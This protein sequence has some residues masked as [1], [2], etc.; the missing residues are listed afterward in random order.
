M[1]KEVSPES[2]DFSEYFD[3]DI[4]NENSGGYEYNLFIISYDNR[5]ISGLNAKTYEELQ[6][7]TNELYNAFQYVKDGCTDYEG[8]KYTYKQAMQENGLVYNP[9]KCSKLKKLFNDCRYPDDIETLAEYLTIKTGKHWDTTSASGYCQGDY[10]EILYCTEIYK[11]PE[12]YGELW[13]GCG[14]EFCFAYLDENGNVKDCSEVY[15]YFVA[16][17]QY[18]TDEELKKVLCEYEGT[19]PEETKVLLIDYNTMHTYTK[20]Q[21]E[22]T[23]I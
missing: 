13:L 12:M 6:E 10:V 11:D 21:Y 2:I 7:E 20:Y 3:G 5:R 9:T 4:F 15:G 22:Y 1:F 18:K 16:D 8:N 14:K 17:C 19:K 23:E